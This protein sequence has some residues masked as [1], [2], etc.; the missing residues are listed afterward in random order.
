[1]TIT[2]SSLTRFSIISR[3]PIRLK[4]RLPEFTGG[5]SIIK[6]SIGGPAAID[7]VILNLMSLN[8]SRFEWR[9][10]DSVADMRFQIAHAGGVMFDRRNLEIGVKR[11]PDF[12]YQ[13]SGLPSS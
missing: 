13:Q 10:H 4:R 2:K 12:A 11:C 3:H 5:P 1:M 8:R 7:V 6:K 9:M